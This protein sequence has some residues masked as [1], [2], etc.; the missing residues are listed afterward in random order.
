MATSKS[1]AAQTQLGIGQQQL[2]VFDQIAQSARFVIQQSADARKTA[3]DIWQGVASTAQRAKEME[4]N[5]YFKER[6]LELRSKQLDVESRL[7]D[8][9]IAAQEYGLQLEG[10]RNNIARDRLNYDMQRQQDAEK[11]KGYA[12]AASKAGA[13]ILSKGRLDY[14]ATDGRIKFLEDRRSKLTAAEKL[15]RGPEIDREL[16]ELVTK[17]STIEADLQRGELYQKEAMMVT[18]GAEPG[19]VISLPGFKFDSNNTSQRPS[20][21]SGINPALPG[22][23]GGMSSALFPSIDGP[24]ANA[25]NSALQELGIEGSVA[26]SGPDRLIGQEPVGTYYSPPSRLSQGEMNRV[27]SQETEVDPFDPEWQASNN[28][29]TPATPTFTRNQII[30]TL[31]SIPND[32]KDYEYQVAQVISLADPETK[33]FIGQQ[34]SIIETDFLLNIG[35]LTNYSNI[36]QP[37]DATKAIENSMSE[38]RR[39]GGDQM[40]ISAL[41]REARSAITNIRTDLLAQKDQDGNSLYYFQPE[42]R[43]YSGDFDRTV[44][45][46]YNEWVMNRG[47]EVQQSEEASKSDAIKTGVNLNGSLNLELV[48]SIARETPM[49]LNQSITDLN[50]LRISDERKRFSDEYISQHDERRKLEVDNIN[51]FRDNFV[52]KDGDNRGQIKNSFVKFVLDNYKK[53]NELN[54]MIEASDYA[55][56]NDAS[57]SGQESRRNRDPVRRERIVIDFLRENANNRMSAFN[58]WKQIKSN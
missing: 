24:T 23:A 57:Q 27:N 12:S 44:A 34:R 35:S 25:A 49:N 38:Y 1:S 40:N 58:L 21:N 5:S 6:E 37:E 10:D 22:E 17:R 30:G 31:N 51:E 56:K 43:S 36:G 47:K 54:S 19:S 16:S 52:I 20:P 39:F 29:S 14:A 15:L 7:T 45:A 41:Q 13:S 11:Y 2:A 48:D 28:T 50:S 46:K 3:A 53:V 8:R 42:S 9:R 55:L 18:A 4:I 26:P 33:A 32:A